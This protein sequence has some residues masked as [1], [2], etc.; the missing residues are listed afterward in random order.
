MFITVTLNLWLLQNKV[1]NVIWC[2]RFTS[3]KI[4][5]CVP[6]NAANFFAKM[7]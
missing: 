4:Y 5:V 3:I 1:F 7:L 6:D 2:L